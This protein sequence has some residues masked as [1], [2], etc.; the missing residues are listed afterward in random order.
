MTRTEQRNKAATAHREVTKIR[1][2]ADRKHRGLE[3]LQGNASG[4]NVKLNDEQR[5]Q[6]RTTVI[7]AR[8]APRIDNANFDITV[9]TVI[10]RSGVRIVPVPTILV[11]IDPAW[12]GLRYFVSNDELVIVNPRNMKIV[13]VVRV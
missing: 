2:T 8:N 7:D 10:P 6:I 9:G 1:T 3:G 13:A 11:R 5:T 12:R 4:M